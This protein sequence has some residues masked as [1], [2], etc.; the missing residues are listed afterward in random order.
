VPLQPPPLPFHATSDDHVAEGAESER[1][2]PPTP[3]TCGEDA[4]KS[5]PVDPSKQSADPLSPEATNT[6][7]PA[8]ANRPS[9][10]CLNDE[11]WSASQ[12]PQLIE[13]TV[14]LASCVAS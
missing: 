7:L 11:L 8:T 2:V 9:T 10:A 6:G 1:L 12:A 14:T 3:V 13:M 5:T 4:G